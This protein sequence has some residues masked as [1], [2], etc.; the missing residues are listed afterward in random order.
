M[1]R[2]TAVRKLETPADTRAA[3]AIARVSYREVARVFGRHESYTGRVLN[4]TARC[5]EKVLG[6]LRRAVS[7][8]LSMGGRH[9]EV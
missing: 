7:L 3:L 2:R 8:I 1:T 9:G 6:E 4:G 5:S